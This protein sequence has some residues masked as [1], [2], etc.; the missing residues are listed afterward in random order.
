MKYNIQK[1]D[2]SQIHDRSTILIIGKRNTGKTFL[3]K[4][5]L[6][7]YKD[8]PEG[9]VIS[10]SEY[11]GIVPETHIHHE[12]KP[13]VIKD[14]IRVQKHRI[15]SEYDPRAF[16]VI[17]N[18]F[19]SN[20]FMKDKNIHMLFT[21]G[22]CYKLLIIIS[23][24]YPL[25]IP[26]KLMCDTDWAFIFRDNNLQSRKRIY[27]LFQPFLKTT[28]FDAFCAIMDGC[29]QCFDCLALH[30]QVRNEDNLF[31][32][33]AE[34]MELD[35]YYNLN[36]SSWMPQWHKWTQDLVNMWDQEPAG[37]F[38]DIKEACR[39]QKIEK[40]VLLYSSLPNDIVRYIFKLACNISS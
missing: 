33:K 40:E 32:Y 11:T 28:T 20:E 38:D 7:N 13:Q 30:L 35:A 17:D 18:S 14:V 19:Y 12:Y 9:T 2:L 27:E 31:W 23:I 21:N 26:C 36:R 39:L 24:A 6:H 5:L 15:E 4:D 3:I 25:D 37:H 16:L 22:M 10:T 8:I 34:N 29:T 1:L